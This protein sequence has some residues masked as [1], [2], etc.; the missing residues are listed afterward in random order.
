MRMVTSDLRC[1]CCCCGWAELLFTPPHPRSSQ[2]TRQCR[3]SILLSF[4]ICLSVSEHLTQGQM[5]GI[6]ER[7]EAT[8]QVG[9][10]VFSAAAVGY[11]SQNRTI[12]SSS[13]W[14]SFVFNSADQMW[15]ISAFFSFRFLISWS[16]IGQSAVTSKFLFLPIP[17]TDWFR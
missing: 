16:S 11:R 8:R 12:S 10:Q 2:S 7:K 6:R 3:G 17:Q 15:L 13:V 4:F 5:I 14:L 1:C 9:S